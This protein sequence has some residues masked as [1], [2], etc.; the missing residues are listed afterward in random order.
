MGLIAPPCLTALTCCLGGGGRLLGDDP[1]FPVLLHQLWTLFFFQPFD[2]FVESGRQGQH[3]AITLGFL[4][5]PVWVQLL[6]CLECPRQEWRVKG[7][8][9]E[10]QWSMLYRRV[11]AKSQP[12]L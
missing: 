1:P 3:C 6:L 11:T 9:S 8:G 10:G 7:L 5:Q 2:E 4:L 12:P